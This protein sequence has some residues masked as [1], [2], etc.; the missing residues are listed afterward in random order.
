MDTTT[1]HSKAGDAADIPTDL[2]TL[3]KAV[4]G[5]CILCCVGLLSF[6]VMCGLIL[7]L[8]QIAALVYG[9][10]MAKILDR[11]SSYIWSCLVLIPVLGLVAMFV[12]ATQG[13]RV[14]AD[15]GY[16]VGFLGPDKIAD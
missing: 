2:P 4:K 5:L 1:P 10:W 3:A 8:A 14:L 13:S 9:F 15:N 11:P 16:R 7:F 12:L 6:A